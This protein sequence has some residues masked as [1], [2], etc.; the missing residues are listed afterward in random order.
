[1]LSTRVKVK[2]L[3]FRYIKELD[4]DE[5]REPANRKALQSTSQI[6]CNR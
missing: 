5:D 4:L 1:M 3:C 6:R 2:D